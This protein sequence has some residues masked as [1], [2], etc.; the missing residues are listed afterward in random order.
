MV[1]VGR[2]DHRFDPLGFGLDD[3][4]PGQDFAG[5]SACAGD[6][7]PRGWQ[8]DSHADAGARFSCPGVSL[9]ADRP[10]WMVGFGDGSDRVVCD[11]FA[12]VADSVHCFDFRPRVYPWADGQIG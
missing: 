8:F 4:C 7:D 10:L 9:S 1:A 2:I 3:F 5:A 11:R 6:H 12:D